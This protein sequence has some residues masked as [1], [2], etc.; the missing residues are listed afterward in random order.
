M[1]RRPHGAAY[2]TWTAVPPAQLTITHG[3]DKI[4]TYQ[5]SKNGTRSFC[6]ICGSHLFCQVEENAID[7][8]M[9]SL[10]GPIDRLPEEHYY[11]DSRAD[12]TDI[13]DNLPKLGGVDGM[14]PLDDVS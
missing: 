13:H 10:H 12:W 3:K 9:A 4:S 14:Q 2:V 11:Y 8:T 6:G 1:C 5:S 7:V